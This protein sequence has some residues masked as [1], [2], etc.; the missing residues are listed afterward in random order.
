[1]G[2]V[3][4]EGPYDLVVCSDVLQYVVDADLVR[5]LAAIES[6]LGGSR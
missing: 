2:R 1:M 5:G 3:G 4:L 6:M